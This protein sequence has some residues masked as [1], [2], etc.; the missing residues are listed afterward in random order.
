MNQIVSYSLSLIHIL[1]ILSLLENLFQILLDTN[2][3]QN[4]YSTLKNE[5]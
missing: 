4:I 5:K 1:Y 3:K 2:V